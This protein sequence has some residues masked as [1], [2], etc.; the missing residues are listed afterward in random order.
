MADPREKNLRIAMGIRVKALRKS[1]GWNQ[2]ELAAVGDVSTSMI[3]RVESG[4]CFLSVPAVLRLA[5][6]FGVEPG[7]VLPDLDDLRLAGFQ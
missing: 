5:A 6:A 3:S 2:G 1:R 4:G 7:T